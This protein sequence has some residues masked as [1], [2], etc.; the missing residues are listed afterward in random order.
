MMDSAGEEISIALPTN[1]S[2]SG[3]NVSIQFLCGLKFM[4]VVTDVIAY[5][6]T[7][8]LVWYFMK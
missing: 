6:I 5:G 4:D 2:Q 8:D 3:M 1:K 7:A